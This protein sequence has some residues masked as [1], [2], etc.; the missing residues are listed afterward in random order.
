MH[1]Q[2]IRVTLHFDR[3]RLAVDVKMNGLNLSIRRLRA[4][5]RETHLIHGLQQSKIENE[6]IFIR[7]DAALCQSILQRQI[8][9]QAEARSKRF[10]DLNLRM[11]K[12]VDLKLILQ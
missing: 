9:A 8:G 6:L 7:I 11:L 2:I 3:L 5:K 1:A 4:A 10:L 12:L